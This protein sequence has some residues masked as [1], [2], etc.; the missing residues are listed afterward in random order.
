MKVIAFNCSPNRDQGTTAMLLS[1]FVEGMKKAG[2]EVE[3]QYLSDLNIEPCRGCTDS[4]QFIPD[5]ECKIMD[6][7]QGLY[8][9]LKDSDIWVFGSPNYLNNVTSCLKN[10]LDRMEPLFESHY[11]VNVEDKTV[12]KRVNTGKNG[13]IVLLSTC[14]LWG[15]EHFN[16]MVEQMRYVADM[17]GREL[18]KP[19]L[20]PHAGIMTILSKLD[21][22]PSDIFEACE[23][24]GYELIAG[25][26]FQ[27]ATLD[28]IK[29]ELVSEDSF[30][31]ELSNMVG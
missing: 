20:R 25:G 7:M 3:T 26:D 17:F 12:T 2:A 8:R 22:N 1:P 5:G 15:I 23:A 28:I 10:L 31:K 14:G 6:D 21:K 13:K 16:L 11:D 29:R 18:C 9:K 4:I 30:I 27:D 19:V 24:A